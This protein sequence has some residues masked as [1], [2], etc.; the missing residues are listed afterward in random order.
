MACRAHALH[1]QLPARPQSIGRLRH[2]V[3]EFAD[4]SGASAGQCANI[5]LAVS[6]AL[7]NAV[8]HAYI[9]D[10]QPGAVAVNVQMHARRLEV[11]VCDAGSGMRP[12]VD[13]PGAGL[14]L[15]LIARLT[16]QLDISDA[17]PGTCVR[18]TFAID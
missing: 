4:S 13:S 2:A 18:M 12:R 3:A 6:E 7:S 16:E 10:D 9:G 17:M 14:G 1:Q 15:P 11:V 8:I 5:A